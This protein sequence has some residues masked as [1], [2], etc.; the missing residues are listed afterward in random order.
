ML[1]DLDFRN[2]GIGFLR[3]FFAAV[4]IWSHG[5]TIGGY[6]SLE[7]LA[8]LIHGAATAGSLAVGAFFVLSGFLITRSYEC[9]GSPGRFVWH[10]FLRIFP[11]FWLCLLVTAFLLAPAAFFHQHAT[12]RGYFDGSD[13]P[14]SYV[15]RNFFLQINQQVIGT[16]LTHS[17]STS[18][19]NA[20]LWTLTYEFL[21]YLI[22]AIIG[23][24][25]VL[26]G[27]PV[28]VAV[29]A[30]ALY[31]VYTIAIFRG[32]GAI[33]ITWVLVLFIYFF[34]GSF[35]YLFRDRLPMSP[36]IAMAS[37]GMLTWSAPMYAYAA[38][39][40]PCLA[41]LV[42]FAA[43]K[44]PIR[45]FDKHVDL[46]YGIYIYAYPVQ[47]VLIIYGLHR[48]GFPLYVAVTLAIVLGLAAASWFAVEQPALS[49]KGL[50]IAIP[51]GSRALDTRDPSPH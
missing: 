6:A 20:S 48:L 5:A 22:V 17:P 29:A 21:C 7:P 47:Q 36:W 37:V 50:R 32:A 10:R 30:A 8:R 44:L 27:R 3:F 19:L 14:W 43:M 41:Y 49:L 2:N 46:S 42:L 33:L 34:A 35:A 26:K 39:I 9:V 16:I 51:F 23:F 24:A 31:T 45:S 25:G 11:G 12:L 4:V 40:P 18:F 1:G 15:G 28:Y 38:I 13:S